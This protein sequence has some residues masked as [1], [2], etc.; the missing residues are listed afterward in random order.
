MIY[1]QSEWLFC[2]LNCAAKSFRSEG[3]VSMILWWE[4]SN[5][6]Q[7]NSKT[8][9]A[10]IGTSFQSKTWFEKSMFRCTG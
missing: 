2:S 1:G 4:A 5:A 6:Q 3:Q 7:G 8:R 9:N 10:Y